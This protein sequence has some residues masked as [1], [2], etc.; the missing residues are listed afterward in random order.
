MLK[1][2][3][4]LSLW[5]QGSPDAISQPSTNLYNFKEMKPQDHINDENIQHTSLS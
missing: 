4:G 5:L 2:D 1:V 3:K